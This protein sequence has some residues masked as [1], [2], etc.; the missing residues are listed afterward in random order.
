M[1]R[2]IKKVIDLGSFTKT[3]NPICGGTQGYC[4]LFVYPKNDEPFIVKGMSEKV[5][6]YVQENVKNIDAILN[7]T[8]WENGK[9]RNYW[10]C[11]AKGVYIT[12]RRKRE[13]TG[14]KLFRVL[15]YRENGPSKEL[16]FRRMPTKWLPE[17]D[18]AT[19]EPN[20][21]W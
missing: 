1:Q 19:D 18:L 11:T 17:Y 13:F 9:S 8:W 7:Y 5:T 3:K 14:R 6:S 21:E 15:C 16:W 10:M 12:T 20:D 2:N 4:V